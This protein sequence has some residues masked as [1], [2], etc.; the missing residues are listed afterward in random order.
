MQIGISIYPLP[1]EHDRIVDLLDS[2]R[3][4]TAANSDCLE[5]RLTTETGA[6][7]SICYLERWQT[8]EALVRHLR[9]ALYCRVLEAMELS[10]STPKIEFFEVGQVGGLDWIAQ[11]RLPG[12]NTV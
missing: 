8:R 1:G 3:L 12:S 2:I 6:G 5:C 10:A 7:R 11:V 4:L 9:S